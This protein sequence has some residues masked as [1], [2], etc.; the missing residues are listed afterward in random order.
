MRNWAEDESGY[1]TS[2][3]DF[4]AARAVAEE[5]EIPLLTADFSAQ[6]RKKVF[7]RFLDGYR[8]GRI[9]NPDLWCNRE[10]KFGPFRDYA[11][12]V[13]GADALATGHYA[14]V[15]QAAPAADGVASMP[16]GTS[17]DD[18]IAAVDPGPA[19]WRAADDNKCQTYFLATVPR[20]ALANVYFPLGEIPQTPGPRP[21]D[22]GRPA[23]S[24]PGPIPPASASSASARSAS[25]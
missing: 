5:L 1:C 9:P 10:V 12:D 23:Q 16:T 6:Y 15:T 13:L 3:A 19:L 22:P 17:P 20:P 2:A 25:S 21:G 24:P 8:A 18:D 14:R 7:E 4:Q 11:F